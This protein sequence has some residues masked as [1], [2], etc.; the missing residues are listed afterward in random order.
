MEGALQ[1]TLGDGMTARSTPVSAETPL[2]PKL[3]L[4]L[5]RYVLCEELGAGGMA[6]VYLGRMELAGGLD[7]LVALKTIHPH[8]ARE[9]PFL[10][11]FLDEARIASHVSHP[12]VC[13]VYDFGEVDGV[14]YL[15]ME[16]LLGEPLFD[17]INRLV[18]RFDEVREV[19]PYLAARVVADAC[20]GLHAAHGARGPDGNTLR[21][22]HRDVSPQNLFITYDG[23]VKVVD[24]GCAKAAQR[25]AHTSTGVMKGKVGYAA[26]EQLRA[27]EV[28]P[29]ADVWAL[30][31]CLWEAL[32]LSPLFTKETAVQTAMSVL[33]DAIPLAS[34][35]RS[36]VPERVARIAERALHRDRDARY[37]SAR[38]LGRDLRT[39][40]ADSGFT[41]EGAELAEWMEL[42]FEEQRE[43]RQAQV[44]RVRELDLRV[45]QRPPERSG[46]PAALVAAPS[47]LESAAEVR[48]LPEGP[49]EVPLHGS[50]TSAPGREPNPAPDGKRFTPAVV[51]PP[52]RRRGPRWALAL[53]LL[54]VLGVGG[55]V[56]NQYYEPAP[57]LLEL[58]G[59]ES[60][61]ARERALD[62]AEHPRPMAA[63]P[64]DDAEPMAAPMAAPPSAV[65]SAA[66]AAP[67]GEASGGAPMAVAI[68]PP[69][70]EEEGDA[71]ASTVG[72][73]SSAPAAAAREPVPARPR[74]RRESG[75]GVT[76]VVSGGGSYYPSYEPSP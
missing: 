29:R 34:D 24:F 37:A 54:P 1:G 33:E 71:A 15:A 11:M 60:A 46:E 32:T 41:L 67:A 31:V 42:L 35:D 72:E 25:V 39:F 63:A 7:R 40:I 57:W 68:D 3:P 2:G 18:D 66:R 38:E 21:I 69:P 47:A 49:P 45:A 30:G 73:G 4:R 22:V 14:Y 19:L 70:R 74:R 6:T 76:T 51:D 75:G 56:L 27:E 13:A 52:A 53:T 58:V 50:A 9:K 44:A 59:R 10:D 5:G 48:R 16:H 17:V 12:N 36:W 43:A 28:D 26:P 23:A 65:P 55:H 62:P 8:L 64:E 20:E 61:T